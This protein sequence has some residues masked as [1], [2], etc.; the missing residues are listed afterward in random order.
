MHFDNCSWKVMCS[1]HFKSTRVPKMVW[2]RS[3]HLLKILRGGRVKQ[4]SSVTFSVSFLF[5]IG[6]TKIFEQV[7]H[8][9]MLPLVTSYSRLFWLEAPHSKFA[10]WQNMPGLIL[11][12]FFIFPVVKSSGL[13]RS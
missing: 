6:L 5:A 13:G 11:F 4:K 1:H 9:G 2:I 8:S 3:G 12:L 7:Y 10:H